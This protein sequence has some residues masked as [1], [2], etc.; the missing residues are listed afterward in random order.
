MNRTA[1]IEMKPLDNR[2]CDPLESE[3]TK[4]RDNPS[5][6]Q[7]GTTMSFDYAALT[8]EAA[9]IPAKTSNGGGRPKKDNPLLPYVQQLVDSMPKDENGKPVETSKGSLRFVIPGLGTL[10]N[11][12]AAREAIGHL[13]RAGAELG[14]TVKKI[15]GQA[16]ENEDKRNQKV[17]GVGFQIW[18]VE[19]Q[20]R[21][22]KMK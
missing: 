1:L 2:P 8:V 7:E 20:T 6:Y 17:L 4:T 14:V 22:R 13:N 15:T 18:T 11:N 9:E 21:T 16:V 19:R 10:D 3:H 12:D 5:H